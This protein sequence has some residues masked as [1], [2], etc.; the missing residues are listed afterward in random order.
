MVE[1][2]APGIAD[3]L[4]EEITSAAISAARVSGYRG[5][6]TVEFIV[7]PN[8]RSYEDGSF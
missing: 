1:A 8:K 2:P 7:D 6:G 5:A 4:R 3:A